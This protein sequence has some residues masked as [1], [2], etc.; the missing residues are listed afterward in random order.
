MKQAIAAPIGQVRLVA[1]PKPFSTQ[2]IDI[3]L[4]AGASL[5][6]MVRAS[7]VT[8]DV[9]PFVFVWLTDAAMRAEPVYIPPE[10]WVRTTPKP[11]IVVTIRAAP[12]KVSVIRFQYWNGNRKFGRFVE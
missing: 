6:D 8:T 12:G 11:G 7:G 4:P 10:H 3:F 1:C 5:L 9:E 2:R